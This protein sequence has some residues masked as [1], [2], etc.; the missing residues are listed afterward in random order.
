MKK[1]KFDTGLQHWQVGG[2]VL[3]F[4]P[5]DP[6]LYSRFL[7]A[8]EAMQKLT[9]EQTLTPQQADASLREQIRT[10]FPDADVDAML[11][12]NLLALCGNG[13]PLVLN[14]LEAVEELL[15]EGARAFSQSV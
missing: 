13:K 3:T 14:F 15:V 11:P 6:N 10:I 2:G 12:Q 1:L 8:V 7:G 4:N 5:G 9:A